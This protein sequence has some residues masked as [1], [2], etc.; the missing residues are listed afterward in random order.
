[1]VGTMVPFTVRPN[2]G[3]RIFVAGAFRS[4]QDW[5]LSIWIDMFVRDL[6][7]RP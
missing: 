6:T 5:L 4:E 2:V 7:V 3:G 1:M